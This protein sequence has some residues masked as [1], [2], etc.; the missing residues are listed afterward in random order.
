LRWEGLSHGEAGHIGREGRREGGR[1]GRRKGKVGRRLNVGKIGFSQN[2]PGI[3][4]QM[5]TQI[6]TKVMEM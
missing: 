5:R 1:R 4:Y 3:S 2:N 6:M